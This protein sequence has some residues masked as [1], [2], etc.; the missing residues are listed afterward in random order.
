MNFAKVIGISIGTLL[1]LFS[2][3]S[4]C[5]G[6][7]APKADSIKTIDSTATHPKS[8][9]KEKIFV[10]WPKSGNW[11]AGEVVP[12]P[13]RVDIFYPK[14]QSANN[15]TEMGTVEY[16]PN[17]KKTDLGGMARIIFLGTQKGSPHAKWNIL[18]KGY[19]DEQ[20][21]S[22]PFTFFRID[23]PD[24]ASG[25]SAQVQ[26]WLLLVGK[27]GLFTVQYSFKGSEIPEKKGNDILETMQNAH[28]EVVK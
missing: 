21:K 19:K 22:Y 4:I 7:P 24:F 9:I 27:S 8:P 23:C 1:L 14:G 16:D 28:I 25:E 5:L 6:G 13:P 26:F 10:N 3:V 15:W 12:G 17:W 20:T 2:G 18:A 11:V